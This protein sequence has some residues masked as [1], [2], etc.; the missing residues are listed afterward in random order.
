MLLKHKAPKSKLLAKLRLIRSRT[1]LTPFVTRLTKK[2]KL[3][4]MLPTLKTLSN[5]EGLVPTV[6]APPLYGE[7][8][9]CFMAVPLSSL[10]LASG[11]K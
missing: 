3:L 11:R 1:R 4:A 6:E 7:E 5:Y 2:A 9:F 8:L 10:V